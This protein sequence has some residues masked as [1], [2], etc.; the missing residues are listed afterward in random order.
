MFESN[1]EVALAPL[2]LFLPFATEPGFSALWHH[3]AIGDEGPVSANSF[4]PVHFE[5]ALRPAFR[6][7]VV[8]VPEPSSVALFGAVL[9]A[10]AWKLRP[11]HSST[12]TPSGLLHDDPIPRN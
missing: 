12:K 9:A 1:A 5:Q 7:T 11:H 10:V 6:V 2:S 4:N 8:P 3:N